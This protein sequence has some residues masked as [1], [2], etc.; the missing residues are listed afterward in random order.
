MLKNELRSVVAYQNRADSVFKV[1]HSVSFCLTPRPTADKAAGPLF[2]SRRR[3]GA[4]GQLQPMEL[5]Q[6]RHL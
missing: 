1:S 4:G 5:P 2:A 3:G 6:F